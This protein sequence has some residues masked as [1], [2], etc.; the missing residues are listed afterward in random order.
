MPRRYVV[1]SL[2][3]IVAA[4]VCVRLGFWQLSR[5]GQRRARNAVVAARLRLPEV[6]TLAALPADTAA[7]RF[8][9]V[10]LAGRFDYAH[11]VAV[12]A[13]IREGSPGVHLVTPLRLVD[14]AAGAPAVLVNRGWAYS[15]NGAAVTLERW[16]EKPATADSVVTVW[17]FVDEI[18]PRP[19]RFAGAVSAAA[20][21]AGPQAVL[22]LDDRELARRAGY[23]IAPLVLTMENPVPRALEDSVP[24]RLPVPALDE[25]P[26][27]NYA[28]QWFAFAAIALGGLG[29]VLVARRRETRGA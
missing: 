11:E 5:L 29:L 28:L 15:P 16:R 12:M 8:R 22:W 10:R 9:R 4:A 3:A 7:S 14:A 18:A 1:F 21:S 27:L 17:G 23:A 20:G 19:A 24:A 2:I 25:G 26:H 13:R 6:S